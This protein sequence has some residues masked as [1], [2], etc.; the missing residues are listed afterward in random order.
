MN[1]FQDG[2]IGN[3]FNHISIVAGAHPNILNLPKFF[4][5]A[6]AYSII[7]FVDEEKNAVRL[8]PK[9][10]LVIA[11]LE[12][13]KNLL[14]GLPDNYRIYIVRL[15]SNATAT[16]EDLDY[17]VQW[18][19]AEMLQISDASNSNV[20]YGLLQRLDKMQDMKQ[21]KDIML[22]IQRDSYKELNIKL[23]LNRLPTLKSARFYKNYLNKDERIY[24]MNHLNIPDNWKLRNRHGFV[25]IERKETSYTETFLSNLVNSFNSI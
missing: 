13:G 1:Q 14:L 19:N 12:S 8:E 20:S 15:S 5:N 25:F 10:R 6:T 18:I 22:N 3:D 16:N 11:D 23:F 17:I 4:A 9:A 21:L 7:D 2:E 24:F